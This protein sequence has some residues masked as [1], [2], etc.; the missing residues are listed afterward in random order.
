MTDM[1]KFGGF[2]RIPQLSLLIRRVPGVGALLLAEIIKVNRDRG[3]KI[4]E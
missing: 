2:K 4:Y 1:V 3:I